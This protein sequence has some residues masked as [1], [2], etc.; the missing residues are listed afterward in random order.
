MAGAGTGLNHENIDEGWTSGKIDQRLAGGS[1]LVSV[2][3][4]A[5]LPFLAE[6]A[7]RG[8]Y[9]HPD[10]DV[11]RLDVDQLGREPH[12]LVHLDD[13]HHVRLLHLELGRG[14]VDDRVGDHAPLPAQLE[15]LHLADRLAAADRTD[16]PRREIDLPAV[17]TFRADQ[18]VATLDLA[19][20]AGDGQAQ[21][22]RSN[23]W[24]TAV[25]PV[26]P[27]VCVRPWRARK[28]LAWPDP[29]IRI[30]VS[31]NFRARCASH[32]TTAAAPSERGAQSN[33]PRGSATQGAWRTASIVISFWN[34]ASGFRAPFLWFFTATAAICSRVVPN[35]CI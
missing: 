27:R 29:A 11:L 24:T 28:S 19:P 10:A 8:L 23:R 3:D 6:L 35:S 4:D 7:E 5:C 9:L 16:G 14:I 26:P 32:R 2:V 20:K 17:A 34:C 12:A 21:S 1:K 13:R 33:R 30:G 18:V 25:A 22:P 31:L 15:P